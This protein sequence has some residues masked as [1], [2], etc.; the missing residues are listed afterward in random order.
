MIKKLYNNGFIL[1]F[2]EI[3]IKKY[4]YFIK[5]LLKFFTPITL[6]QFVKNIH[7][8]KSLKNKFVITFDDGWKQTSI[9]VINHSINS[10]IPITLYVPT[11]ILDGVTKLWFEDFDEKIKF[12]KKYN[13]LSVPLDRFKTILKNSNHNE[14]NNH[15]E[16]Y[17]AYHKNKR[18]S[19][20][21]KN[22][23]RDI[24]NNNI[25]FQSHTHD[26][27]SITSQTDEQILSQ[28]KTSKNIL[29]NLTQKS[30]D[31]LCYPYGLLSDIGKQGVEVSKSFFK[32]AVTMQRAKIN[33]N[34]NLHLLPRISLYNKDNIFSLFAKII[35]AKTI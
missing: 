32:S 17:Y 33:F 8:K 19:F 1:C 6:N 5:F 22:F 21:D 14:S 9:G 30:V 31:H 15:F 3:E 2:H 28:F 11:I 23:I 26:H 35:S 12:L 7:N 16:D 27:Q 18:N 10:N 25:S 34:S 4:E 20:I 24:N 13:K 29:E